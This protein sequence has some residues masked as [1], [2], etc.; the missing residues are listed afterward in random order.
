M[1]TSNNGHG[2]TSSELPGVTVALGGG[3]ARG[4]A[5]F[6]VLSVLEAEGIRIQGVVGNSAGAIAGAVYLQNPDAK[7]AARQTLEF[8]DSPRFQRHKLAFRLSKKDG[9]KQPPTVLSRLLSGWRRQVAMHLLFR[10]PS[11]FHSRRL[12]AVIRAIV[13]EINIEDARLPYRVVALD[14]ATGEEV[15]LDSGNVHEALLASCSVAGFFPPVE[16]NGRTLI[17]SGQSDNLPVQAAKA[18]N[19]DPVIAVNLSASLEHRDDFGTGI[20]VMLRSEE[21]GS[22]WNSRLRGREALAVVT[23][24]MDGRFWLDFSDPEE[25]YV[26]GEE[27]AREAMPQIREALEA[28]ARVRSRASTDAVPRST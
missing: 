5:H 7:S 13:E 22:R 17:D 20:E 10:R 6:G 15:M 4:L 9:A 16:L 8:L 26:A 3:G 18:L 1:D 27:A 28:E 2:H 23:P 25:A 14:L 21:I 24:Q 19:G 12:D 11:L